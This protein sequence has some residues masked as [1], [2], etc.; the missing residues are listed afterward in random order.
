MRLLFLIFIA[1]VVSIKVIINLYRWNRTSHLLAL[2]KKWVAG[3]EEPETIVEKKHQVIRLWKDAGLESGS[4]P[5]IEPVGYD[6][7]R[8][9]KVDIFFNFP[10]KYN[11]DIVVATLRFFHEAIGVYKKRIFDAINPFEWLIFIVRMPELSLKSAGFE[12][13]KWLSQILNIIWWIIATLAMIIMSS[14]SEQIK[15][16]FE[17]FIGIQ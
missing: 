8:T 13:K 14:Y 1:I 7:L 17:K 3:T 6:R 2:Y 15:T 11:K 4:I 5:I 12:P 10:Q 16:L 9:M